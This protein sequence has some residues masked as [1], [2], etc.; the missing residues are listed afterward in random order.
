MSLL[1]RSIACN[2]VLTYM[3]QV[4]NCIITC[5]VPIASEYIPN[6]VACVVNEMV[7]YTQYSGEALPCLGFPALAVFESHRADWRKALESSYL[8]VVSYHHR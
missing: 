8:V 1:S 2:E 7:L 5:G 3:V 4:L 6:I